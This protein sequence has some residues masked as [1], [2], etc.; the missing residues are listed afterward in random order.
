[1]QSKLKLTL[2]AVAVSVALS[3]CKS[4]DGA[5][6]VEKPK[7]EQA[8][9]ITK[10]PA[11][12]EN[13]GSN[14]PDT[15]AETTTPT[16]PDT[17]VKPK[18]S[19][20]PKPVVPVKP[21][22]PAKPAEPKQPIEQPKPAEPTEPTKPIEEK[23]VEPQKPTPSTAVKPVNEDSSGK[24][25]RVIP[26][27]NNGLLSDAGE[28]RR[29]DRDHFV[30]PDA[31]GSKSPFVADEDDKSHNYYLVLNLGTEDK[32]NV[33]IPTLISNGE[34]YLGKHSGVL[35]DNKLEGKQLL[36]GNKDM[37]DAK[38][39]NYLYI[40]QPYSSYGALFTNENDSSLF[41][42]R[43]T[44]GRDGKKQ[45]AEGSG[46]SY[47]E[48]GVFDIVNGKAQWKDGLVGDAIYKGNVI[49]RFEKTV[50]GKTIA[51]APQLDGDV[52]LKLHL[53]NEWE[54]NKLTGEIDS[55]TLGKIKL[56]ES[57]LPDAK[58]LRESISF[59]DSGI[60]YIEKDNHLSGYYSTKFVGENLNDAIGTIELESD[61]EEGITKYNAVFG[62]TK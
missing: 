55:V 43:L 11:K 49:A 35:N 41:N 17:P 36:V 48:Y 46:S 62:G 26:L 5:R 54:K 13:A 21:T 39:I 6:V 58:Y 52:T 60:S 1:M 8:V 22:E 61:E 34:S 7:T 45:S 59:K 14:K 30:H 44:T 33:R 24:L 23:P 47:A 40:N 15:K 20:Q 38:Q 25:W 2:A 10:K 28:V 31:D 32:E 37:P 57:E 51:Y 16:K 53:D 18:P 3:G 9:E 27:A 19:E 50:D 12:S 56:D 42:I 4:T 29:E